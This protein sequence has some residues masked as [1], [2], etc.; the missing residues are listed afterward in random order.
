MSS[1]NQPSKG[2]NDV[3][4]DDSEYAQAI[5]ANYA[6]DQSNSKVGRTDSYKQAKTS[7]VTDESGRQMRNYN[8]LPRLGKGGRQQQRVGRGGDPGGRQEADDPE[9]RSLGAGGRHPRQRGKR[10]DDNCQMM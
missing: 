10:G 3:L 8:S 2:G 6:Q 4:P 5:S 9:T 7:S 1:L